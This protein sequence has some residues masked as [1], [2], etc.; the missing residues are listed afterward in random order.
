M[1]DIKF[2]GKRVDNGEWVYGYY[3]FYLGHHLILADRNMIIDEREEI[4]GYYI[5]KTIAIGVPEAE[6]IPE[7]VGQYTGLKDKNGTEIYEGDMVRYKW[8]PVFEDDNGEYDFTE[9]TI[10]WE[11][12]VNVAVTYNESRMAFAFGDTMYASEY[13]KNEIEVIGNIHEQEAK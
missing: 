5:T 12:D 4:D 10:G 6:V 9:K 3:V 11:F 1:R 2:R 8:M 7:T 13:I